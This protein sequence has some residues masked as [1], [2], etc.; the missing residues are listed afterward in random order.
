MKDSDADYYEKLE[1]TPEKRNLQIKKY[2][3]RQI[4]DYKPPEISCPDWLHCFRACVFACDF[5]DFSG[6]AV[7]LF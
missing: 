1:N 5:R 7:V 4:T 2:S 3:E 6:Y